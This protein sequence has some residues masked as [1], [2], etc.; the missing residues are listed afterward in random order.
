MERTKCPFCETEMRKEF[1][2]IENGVQAIVETCH[3]CKD[4]WINETEHDRL[5]DLF[6]RKKTA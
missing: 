4:E 1:K 2:E 6:K 3:Q 5:V